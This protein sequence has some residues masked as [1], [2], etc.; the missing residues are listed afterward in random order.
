MVENTTVIVVDARNRDLKVFTAS[1]TNVT[2]LGRDAIVL[3]KG[4]EVGELQKIVEV[5]VED[6]G[7]A[8]YVESPIVVIGDYQAKSSAGF[9]TQL[10]KDKFFGS[11]LVGGTGFG[12]EIYKENK[13]VRVGDGLHPFGS[14]VEATILPPGTRV[15]NIH[16]HKNSNPGTANAALEGLK[17]M[18]EISPRTLVLVEGQSDV[19][20]AYGFYSQR[21][22]EKEEKLEFP[23]E[24]RSDIFSL[25]QM[26]LSALRYA[27]RRRD[28]KESEEIKAQVF[29]L[30]KV[31]LALKE[32]GEENELFQIPSLIK[33][34]L[35]ELYV[36]TLESL[37]EGMSSEGWKAGVD[38]SLGNH[39]TKVISP[40]GKSFSS[41]SLAG[42][43][44]TEEIFLRMACNAEEEKRYIRTLRLSESLSSHFWYNWA[45]VSSNTGGSEGSFLVEA[46]ITAKESVSLWFS[47]GEK[48]LPGGATPV[49]DRFNSAFDWPEHHLWN[50]LLE[51][52]RIR[53]KA[54]NEEGKEVSQ[55]TWEK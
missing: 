51:I 20:A 37:V 3:R 4:V 14:P 10:G 42:T 40:G 13:L 28:H 9:T 25:N 6:C 16:T 23:E 27:V 21:T 18:A 33:E 44:N 17:L 15:R 49:G 29:L 5:K 22:Q 12:R 48:P 41:S 53:I 26:L 38:M 47:R 32:A 39:F 55:K 11:V 54:F 52:K 8:W 7:R 1:A 46:E 50:D 31:L 24:H 43:K 30:A 35:G 19:V 2:G 34:V 45:S 36:P